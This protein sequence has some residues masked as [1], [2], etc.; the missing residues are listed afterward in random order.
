MVLVEGEYCPKVQHYCVHWLDDRE[1][2]YARC[3]QYARKADCLA[4]REHLR[5]CI[6]REEFTPEGA[7]LPQNFLS[8]NQGAKLC[9]AAA[10]RLCHEREWNFACEGEEMRPYPYGWSREPKCNYD[11]LDLFEMHK[12]KQVLRDLRARNSDFPECASPFGVLGLVGNLD[13]PV[14]REGVSFAPM[15]TALKGGWWM[16]ARNRCRPATTSHD[17]DYDNVQTGARCCAD[18]VEHG[19]PERTPPHAPS[20]G[21]VRV[22]PSLR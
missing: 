7:L 11:R 12:G 14:L 18:V 8:L 16:P 20:D 17:D 6:D 1:L 5:F 10:K 19:A 22:D 13:E 4:P 15:R 3:G 21:L 2:P 9:R